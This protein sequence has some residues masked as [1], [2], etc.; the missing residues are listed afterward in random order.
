MVKR[1]VP[2]FVLALALPGCGNPA[3]DAAA[4]P[5][6]TATSVPASSPSPALSPS[7]DDLPE[8]PTEP[9]CL[10]AKGWTSAEVGKWAKELIRTDA[11][12]KLTF[13]SD[14]YGDKLCQP[15]K[16]QVQFWRV[17]F[18]TSTQ[19]TYELTSVLRKQ[20]SVDGRKTV[21]VA[22]PKGF[23]RG[24]CRGTILA[25]YPGGPLSDTELPDRLYASGYSGRSDHFFLKSD[26]VFYTFISMPEISGSLFSK[27]GC[28]LKLTPVPKK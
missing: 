28:E 9:A 7:P 18:T 4:N 3:R 8:T 16:I 17:D 15:V 14:G 6:G 21:T 20:V 22:A 5:A 23:S 25:A 1:V 27:T 12:G 19:T 13:S 24:S 26:R 11:P 10:R 2:F